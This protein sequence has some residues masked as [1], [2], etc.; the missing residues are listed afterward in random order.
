MAWLICSSSSTIYQDGRRWWSWWWLPRRSQQ[1]WFVGG[2]LDQACLTLRDGGPSVV[3]N[4]RNWCG[5]R[6]L[7]RGDPFITVDVSARRQVRLF[8]LPACLIRRDGGPWAPDEGRNW[9]CVSGGG[10]SL[11]EGGDIKTWFHRRYGRGHNIAPSRYSTGVDPIRLRGDWWSC[12]GLLASWGIRGHKTEIH[13]LDHH[14]DH[15]CLD[16]HKSD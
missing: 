4:N 7:L 1:W 8:E 14:I 3:D 5:C 16:L 2:V 9:C 12:F 15:I 13:M 10:L 11:A 6:C